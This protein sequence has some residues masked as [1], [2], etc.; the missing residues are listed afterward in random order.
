MAASEEVQVAEQEVDFLNEKDLYKILGVSR[1]AKPD[2][3][4]KSYRNLSL[5]HH[6]DKNPN[7]PDSKEKFQRISEAY[8]V[9]SDSKKRLQYDKSGDM[10]LEDFDMDQ[11]MNM[12]VGEMMGEGGMVDDMMKEVLPWKDDE[13]KMKQFMEEK[14]KSKGKKVVCQIC[15]HTAST[16][17]L[18]SA[19]FEKEHKW[20]CEDWGKE[21]LD[22]MKASFESFMKQVTGI[23]NDTGTFVLPD[24]S[25]ADMLKVKG[26]PD[27]RQHM[28][29]KVDKAMEE[30]F[31]KEM[32]RK[33]DAEGSTYVPTVE[34]IIKA[35]SVF[36]VE[37]AE[38]EELTGNK[39]KLLRRLRKAIDRLNDEEDEEAAMMAQMEAMGGLGGKGGGKGGIAEMMAAM[40]G[41]GMPPELEAMLAG[42]L[43]DPAMLE[44]LLSGGLGDLGGLGGM[45]GGMGGGAGGG[46]DDD[47]PDLDD[48]EMPDLVD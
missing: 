12:W 32:Y 33:L 44:A 7:D 2:V 3:I 21:T 11:F 1:G 28:Q 46:D 8:S 36:K 27:I 16:K 29:K 19:H 31:V 35:L 6:P 38:A 13:D 17:R 45:P 39:E 26:V 18:M 41:G 42:G 20:D 43:D 4:K 24:G 14:I 10:D 5:K 15:Q 25:T 30:D 48:D 37:K 23:G 47:I 34:E 22:G 9:L 40:G